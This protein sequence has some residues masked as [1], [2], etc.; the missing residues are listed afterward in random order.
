MGA[1]PATT[2]EVLRVRRVVRETKDTVTL[3]LDSSSRPGG[4]P[5]QPGQFTMLYAFGIGD[6]P[7]SISG[8]PNR[9]ERLVQ[10]VRSAGAVTAA[11]AAIRRGG[12]VGVRGPFG[13][14]WPMELA[15][16][17]DLL[18]I[19]GGLGLAP[20]RPA[21]LHVLA[22]RRDYDRV[23]LL[24]GTRSPEVLL[25]RSEL[26]KWADGKD[27]Q[28]LITVDRAPP[29]WRGHVGVATA[30]LPEADARPDRTVAFVCGP[31]LMMR[32]AVRELNRFG[33]DDARIYVSMERNMK[34]AV[35]HCGHCQYG[36]QFI[37]KDGP[38]LRFD[39]LRSW[40]WL[41]EV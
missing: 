7:I 1:L 32:F 22:R 34:C 18:L 27:L 41:K 12:T 5:F 29:G 13:T 39:L 37:C 28:V 3:S 25:F 15:R 33:V 36:P 17:G 21:L 4:F 30:L 2:P 14:P 6:V 31:E 35:G 24:V 40:F 8:D 26:S 23:S 38:V 9:P 20:L 11:L 16:G 19:A 10:T